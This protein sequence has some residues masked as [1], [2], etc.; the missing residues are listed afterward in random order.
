MLTGLRVVE[1]AAW[2]AGG[3]R[4]LLVSAHR[5]HVA[6]PLRAR[7]LPLPVTRA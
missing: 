1:L 2:V 6:A 7:S 4:A 5:P 3:R